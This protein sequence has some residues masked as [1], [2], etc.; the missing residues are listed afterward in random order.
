M[1]AHVFSANRRHRDSHDSHNMGEL[2]LGTAQLGQK[3]GIANTSGQPDQHTATEM[4]RVAFE[5]GIRFFDTAADYGESE[6]VLGQAFRDLRI[7]DTVHVVTKVEA[8]DAKRIEQRASESFARL[9]TANLYG[10]LL[11]WN[12]CKD[13]PRNVLSDIMDDL[14]H[15]DLVEHIGT[16]VYTPEDAADALTT[17]A[18][19]LLQIPSNVLDR[20]FLE[21]GIPSVAREHGTQLFIRSIFLQGLL[22][23]DPLAVPYAMFEAKPYLSAFHEFA[24]TSGYSSHALTLQFIKWAYPDAHLVVGAETPRQVQ[25]HIDAWL[26]TVPLNVL[27][28]LRDEFQKVPERVVNPLLWPT[29]S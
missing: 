10:V 12:D 4:V 7:V 11:R 23:M 8:S 29:L 21:S 24:R 28:R 27:N 14:E 26:L 20:R 6:R 17:G 25:E 3:Y 9:G 18:F 1:Y 19:S 16:S 13:M 22:F 2:V 15:S 5:G